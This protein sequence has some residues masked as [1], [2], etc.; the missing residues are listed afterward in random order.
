MLGG[1]PS[2]YK[3]PEAKIKAIYT[4]L[5]QDAIKRNALYE[6]GLYLKSKPDILKYGSFV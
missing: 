1:K 6:A 2:E 5:K 3:S 4:L